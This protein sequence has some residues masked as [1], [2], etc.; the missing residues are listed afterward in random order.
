MR[1]GGFEIFFVGM[2]DL[3]SKKQGKKAVCGIGHPP[4]KHP[5]ICI[6]SRVSN[7]FITSINH[8]LILLQFPH[9]K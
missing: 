6:K 9:S 8:N 3:N 2:Q 1:Y 5:L 7:T 4:G